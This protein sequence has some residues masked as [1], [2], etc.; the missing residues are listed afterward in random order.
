MITCFCKIVEENA[1]N[2]KKGL[3]FKY[4]LCYNLMVYYNNTIQE[5]SFKK[6]K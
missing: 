2:I 4:V 5:T 3:F 1:K 6:S